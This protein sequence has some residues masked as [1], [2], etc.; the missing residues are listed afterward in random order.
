MMQVLFRPK[1]D[2]CARVGICLSGQG[3]N[4]E[5]ILRTWR[6]RRGKPFKVCCLITD[7]P[8]SSSSRALGQRF[9]IPLIEHDLKDFY[10]KRGLMNTGLSTQT[11]R[12][13]RDEWTEVLRRK[14]INLE[15]DFLVF[16]G[17][18]PLTNIVEDYLCLNMH[19][20]DLSYEKNG[21]RHL[22]GLHTVP[23]ERAILEN[24]AY[25]RSSV[26]I[27]QAYR[28]HTINHDIDSGP[29]LGIS[30]KI[31]LDLQGYSYAE[32]RQIYQARPERCPRQGFQD[33][34]EKLAKYNQERLKKSGDLIIFPRVV[35]DVAKGKFAL[36]K[37][38]ELYYQDQGQWRAIKA[39]CYSAVSQILIPSF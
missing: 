30:I 8:E 35:I 2:K 32:L 20:G 4:A 22:T 9:A 37:S 26:I 28:A 6:I 21:Q 1:M 34:L 12:E 36:N 5:Q 17:F 33:P 39:V 25:L 3:S 38:K 19:P 24:L 16:A 15:L 10:L 7:R 31:P 23:T 27:S 18:I 11:G 14:L 13:I 29:L